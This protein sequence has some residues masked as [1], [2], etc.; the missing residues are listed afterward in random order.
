MFE[1]LLKSL[2]IISAFSTVSGL[3][4]PTDSIPALLTYVITIWM[5]ICKDILY[6]VE[7]VLIQK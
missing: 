1:G 6:Q 5:Y 7:T 2:S 3:P 4:T